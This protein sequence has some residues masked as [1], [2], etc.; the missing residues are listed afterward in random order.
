MR[1]NT[2]I[3]RLLGGEEAQKRYGASFAGSSFMRDKIREALTN[4]IGRVTLL[5]EAESVWKEANPALALS[6]LMGYRRGLRF[7]L[8]FLTDP[9]ETQTT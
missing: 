5:S 3:S 4:E 7:A 1:I 6:D 8:D 9:Q 2:K